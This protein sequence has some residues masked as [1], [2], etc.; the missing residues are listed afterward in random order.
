MANPGAANNFR[1]DFQLPEQFVRIRNNPYA[2]I[3]LMQNIASEET[4]GE[5][6]F[7]H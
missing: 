1:S 7:A 4:D 3:I 6:T 2:L 5:K